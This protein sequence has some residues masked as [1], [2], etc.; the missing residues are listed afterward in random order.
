MKLPCALRRCTAGLALLAGFALFGC[1]TDE[2][3]PPPAPPPEVGFVVV[4]QSRVPRTVELPG[5]LTAYEM[6]EVRP[7][8]AGLVQERLF[9]EG[10]LVRRGQT[11]YRIDPRLYAATLG[12]ARANLASAE[13]TAEAARLRAERLAPLAKLEAVSTQD[14][15]DAQAT[16]RQ[17]AAAVAQNRAQL[18]TARINLGFT[19]V[20]APITG[21]IGRSFATVGALVSMNQAEPLAII[22]RLDPIFADIQ[23]S[24]ADL[25]ALRRA[26]SSG[27]L[28]PASAEVRL[29]LED[30]SDYPLVGTVQ[31]SEVMVNPSTGTV[32]LRARFRNLDGL[33]LPGMF[34]RARFAQGVDTQAILVPQAAVSR[35][36]KGAAR[37]FVVSADNKAARRSVVAERTQGA[38]WVV[39]KGLAPGDRVIVQGIGKIEPG[40]R[41][42]PVPASTPQ[43]LAAPAETAD[44]IPARG[45]R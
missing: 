22:Q 37:V 1:G 19:N 18:D 2:D 28:A 3:A 11:L 29:R 5:R 34:V 21:R 16:A 36:P 7:Q 9:T 32:T 33:L 43:R 15:T 8:V 13:A 4:S 41:V 40:A 44:A 20:P 12:E 10:T 24:S 17:A 45:G 6:S 23:Q 14:L 27:G 42:R 38:N 26:L 39:T 31:F 25:L 35:D 30:G